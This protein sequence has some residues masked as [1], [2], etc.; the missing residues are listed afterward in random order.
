LNSLLLYG[1]N[2]QLA[3]VRVASTPDQNFAKWD[4]LLAERPVP[5]ICAAD[6]HARVPLGHGLFLR[7][8]GYAPSFR[9][10][11]QHVLLPP[12]AGGGDSSLA[13]APEILDALRRGHSFCALDALYPASGFSF[14]VSSGASSGGPGDFLTWAGAGRIRISVPSGASLPLIKIFRDGLEIA[15]GRTWTVDIPITGAGRYRT[16]VFLRQPG[17][18]GLRRWTLWAFTNPVYVTA[19]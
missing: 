12:D 18:T 6:T 13:N 7:F 14:R 10:A 5:G 3:L 15:E 9:L 4:E 11:R 19:K 8:P 16:E 1:V 17:L 2:N